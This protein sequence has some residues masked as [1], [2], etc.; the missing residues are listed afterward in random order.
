ME[1]LLQTPQSY[2]AQASYPLWL[3]LHG[4]FAEA[5]QALAMFGPEAAECDAFLLASKPLVRVVMATA[6]LFLVMQRQF[7][8]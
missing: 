7:V 8:I 5:E 6:G 4:A 3:V 1:H 2:D